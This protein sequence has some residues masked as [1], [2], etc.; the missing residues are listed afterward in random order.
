VSSP[1]S[2][3]DDREFLQARLAFFAKTMFWLLGFAYALGT[4]MFL[5][6]PEYQPPRIKAASLICGIGIAGTAASWFFLRRRAQPAWILR[7]LDASNMIVAGL[8]FGGG[9]WLAAVT[10][11]TL[12]APFTACILH[13]FARVFI[14]PSTPARTFWLSTACMIPLSLGDLAVFQRSPEAVGIPFAAYVIGGAAITAMTVTLAA[15]G[16]SVIHGL[17][18]EVREARRFGQY[19][20]DRKLGEGGM[21]IVYKAHHAL[22]RRPT[23]IKLLPPDKAGALD[24]ARFEREVQ[25]TAELTHP[26]TISIFDYGRSADGVFYYVMEYLD[27]IDLESL[28]GRFGALPAARAVQIVMQICAALDEAHARGIIHRDIKPANVILCRRGQVPDFVKVVDFGLVKEIARNEN[29]TAAGSIA[30]TPAY[31]APEALTDP[32]SIGPPSDLY[33]VGALGYFL[34]TGHPVFEGKTVLE[35]CS[36][37]L[38]SV[39]PP[40]SKR[41]ERPVSQELERIL[42][43]C[44]EKAPADRPKSARALADSLSSL[45]HEEWAHGD[46]LAWWD[47][48]DNERDHVVGVK[49]EDEMADT[50]AVMPRA[51]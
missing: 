4:V 49:V 10:P 28:V 18:R 12:F 37:H 43:S 17:R 20:L 39:P 30:G 8:M 35:V 21:G 32:D 45:P 2:T 5:V 29:V 23:A 38:H 50:I 22:L 6:Y 3:G 34:V 27:G 40:P 25:L 1:S 7:T 14:V 13:I 51:S 11:G 31:L 48:F 42:L 24:I 47:T 15:I 16:T 9:A 33:A 36:H 19:T 44:L 26:N 46:A 41:T